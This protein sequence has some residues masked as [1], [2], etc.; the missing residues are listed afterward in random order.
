VAIQLAILVSAGAGLY[1]VALVGLWL[2]AG[3]PDGVEADV[4]AFIRSRL[5]RRKPNQDSLKAAARENP[6][7]HGPAPHP[8]YMIVAPWG[9][10]AIG[11]VNTAIRGL[12]GALR[13]LEG[14]RA[15]LLI[16]TGLRP[17]RESPAPPDSSHG[18]CAFR[19]LSRAVRCGR[20]SSPCSF[21]FPTALCK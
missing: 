21:D 14:C 4:L 13:E 5:V 19:I 18:S 12:L 7:G 8:C 6:L 9:L 1:V 11:G 3:F 16:M 10:E 2:L 15:N 17:G 20:N